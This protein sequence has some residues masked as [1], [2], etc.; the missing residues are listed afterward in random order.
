MQDHIDLLIY[1]SAWFTWLLLVI[2]HCRLTLLVYGL[3]IGRCGET[4]TMLTGGKD[5]NRSI[6]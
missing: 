2:D 4:L 6:Y 1:Q 3:Y 5:E